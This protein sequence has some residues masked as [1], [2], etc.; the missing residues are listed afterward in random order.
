M[1]VCVCEEVV[2]GGKVFVCVCVCLRIRYHA[3]TTQRGTLQRIDGTVNGIDINLT[4]CLL[5]CEVT[6]GS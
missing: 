5:T 4:E 2:E 1:C 6:R 3:N